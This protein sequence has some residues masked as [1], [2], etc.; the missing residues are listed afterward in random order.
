MKFEEPDWMFVT[1]KE[2]SKVP[3]SVR[4]LVV[5]SLKEKVFVGVEYL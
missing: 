3:Q 4:Q 2:Y 1:E 5:Q